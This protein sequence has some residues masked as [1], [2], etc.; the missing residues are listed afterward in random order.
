MIMFWNDELRICPKCKAPV[1]ITD[2]PQIHCPKCH[3]RVRFYNY[4]AL[5]SPPELPSP[6]P[7]GLWNHPTTT[8][9]LSATAIFGLVALVAIAKG[10]VVPAVSALAAIGFA[11]FGFVR[12]SEARVVEQ[13]LAHAEQLLKYA[14][15]S[16]N[17][18]KD[19]VARYNY[20][21]ATGDTRVEHYHREIYLRAVQER[22]WAKALRDEAARDRAAVKSVESRIFAMAER[23]VQD[24]LKWTSTKL[25]PDPENYQKRKND[26]EKTFDFVEGVG[27]QLPGTI[28]KDALGKL[29]SDY[30]RVVREYN[31]KEEQ[32]RINQRMREE[33]KLRREWEKSV[34]EA[35]QKERELQ[36]RLEESLRTHRDAHA[37][38]IEEL[39]RQLAEA[40]SNAERAKSMAQVTKAGHVY[41]LSNIGSFGENVFKVGMTRRLEPEDRVKE[42][43][44]A[45]VPFPFDVHAMISCDN[46]P[47]LENTL[48]REL[49]RFRVN[50][51]NLRKEFF[52]VEFD[53]ILSLVRKNHGE[54]E[55]VAEPEALQYRES[56]E[57]SPEDLEELDKEL[58]EI[59]VSMEDG[60]E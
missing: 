13:Q 28:R 10:V 34:R 29:K 35:E 46:A 33:E 22:E 17:R 39:R 59:G 44:D 53:T 27:Y 25:R 57:T 49:T 12:H 7:N 16:R 6:K 8:L 55:Y 47:A 45:S 20:L 42:L 50:R 48:H 5:P 38:E 40:Q 9:L 2:Q 3:A 58:V 23:L 15:T 56:M 32:K 14:E 4:R 21:L 54:V 19:A 30:Q 26:L 43:S 36:Q 11:I 60:E 41:I 24:R 1:E 31:L 37:T 18:L 52:Q 51:V